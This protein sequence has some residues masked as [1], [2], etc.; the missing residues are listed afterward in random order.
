M[1]IAFWIA[2][3][4]CVIT[5]LGGILALRFRSYQGVLFA[6]CAGALMAGALM[7]ILP[8]ALVLSES[9]DSPFEYHHLLGACVFGFLC[10]TCLSMRPTIKKHLRCK[11]HTMPTPHTRE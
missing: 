6:F 4:T 1:V 9:A 7:D 2:G 3:A 10:S 8:E 11:S 5:L